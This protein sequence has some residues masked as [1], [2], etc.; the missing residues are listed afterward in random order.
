MP[1]HKAELSEALARL[2]RVETENSRLKLAGLLVLL[3]GAAVMVMGQAPPCR[4]P[5]R[6]D[7][8]R[9]PALCEIE[10][11]G[12]KL[13]MEMAQVRVLELLSGHII[14][15][16][17]WSAEHKPDSL[18]WYVTGPHKVIKGGV[19]FRAGKLD[20]AM[21]MWSPESNERSDFAASLINLLEKFTKEGSTQCTLTTARDTRPQQE[22]RNALF[23]CGM[24]SIS[25]EHTR[26][27]G[28]SDSA[29]IYE[30]LGNW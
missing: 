21:V 13:A 22:S 15:N 11:G 19:K 26:F 24:R 30:T 28:S 3:V 14:E 16:S 2:E 7:C 10:V 25:I 4:T 6:I 17:I 8:K 20:G 27:Q 1:E 9:N 12:Q 23:E 29:D 18:W 5:M